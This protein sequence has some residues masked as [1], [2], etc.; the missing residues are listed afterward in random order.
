MDAIY[1]VID[2]RTLEETAPSVN[3]AFPYRTDIADFTTIPNGIYPWHWHGEIELFYIE[4]GSLIYRLPGKEYLFEEGDIGFVNTNVLHMTMAAGEKKCLQ[5]EH[6]FMPRLVG[7][8]AGDAIEEEYISPLLRNAAA[9]CVRIPAD[10]PS[11]AFLR[12]QLDR[13]FSLFYDPCF[14]HE[15][16]I[17]NCMSAVWLETARRAPAFVPV[18]THGD[19]QRIKAML[20][21]IDAHYSEPVRLEDIAS[22]AQ[23][24]IREASR[25][26]RRQ[27]KMTAFEYLLQVRLERACALLRSSKLPVTEIAIRCGFASPSYFGKMFREHIHESPSGFRERV[28]G[29]ADGS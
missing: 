9:D 16:L 18:P 23:V 28:N 29:P 25:C 24:G 19:G 21:Y 4:E 5:Q 15:I 27:L 12:G 3:A 6:V 14:G 26:F 11:A 17:R 2:D 20:Q 22:A 8:Q 7:G 13:A 1:T 10:D